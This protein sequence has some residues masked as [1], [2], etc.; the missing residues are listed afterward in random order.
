MLE[1]QFRIVVEHLEL[2]LHHNKRLKGALETQHH[3][4]ACLHGKMKKE[5]ETVPPTQIA[6]IMA[7]SVAPFTSESTAKSAAQNQ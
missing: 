3:I 4:D 2:H 7:K 5:F 6:N 1:V